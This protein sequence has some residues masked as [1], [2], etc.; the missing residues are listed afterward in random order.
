ME[1]NEIL[2]I[3][4]EAAGNPKTPVERLAELAKDDDWEVRSSVAWN[5]KTPVEILS[6]LAKDSDWAVRRYASSTLILKKQNKNDN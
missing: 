6:E 5:P 3:N 2:N 4:I 1:N